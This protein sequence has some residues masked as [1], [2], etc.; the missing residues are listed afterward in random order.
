MTEAEIVKEFQCAGC[1][2]GMD[3]NCGRYK[4][5]P[6]WGFVCRSHVLGTCSLPYVGSFALG[7][8]KGFCRPG[9]D[10]NGENRNKMDIR[11]WKAGNVPA[12]DK[13]NV[14]VWAMERDGFLF[15][16][17]FAPRVN[18]TWVDVID[19][20]TLAMCPNAINVGEFYDE[21]D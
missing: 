5:E 15:V 9:F 4:T 3:T 16:R 17:T 11:L 6:S 20:G 19:G 2:C 21:I 14:A 7:L 8:P 10:S 12:W 13:F 1:V 18:Q